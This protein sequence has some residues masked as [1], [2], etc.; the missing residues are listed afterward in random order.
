[1]RA[2]T[3][4]IVAGPVS[5]STGLESCEGLD[6]GRSVVVASPDGTVEVRLVGTVID[7]RRVLVAMAEV[8]ARLD[9]GA[10]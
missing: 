9:G 2:S 8:G 3:T 5:V 1:V 7:L 10:R 4:V 6:D